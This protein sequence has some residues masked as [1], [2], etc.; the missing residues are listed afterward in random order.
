[1]RPTAAPTASVNAA[2]T[3]ATFAPG[4]HALWVRGRDAAG[5]WGQAARLPVVV[6]GPQPLAVGDSPLDFALKANA[7][8]PVSTTTTIAYGLPL[9]GNVDLAIYDVTG[10][11]IRTLVQGD[12]P[13]GL[14]QVEWDR[15]TGDGRLVQPGV[16]YY[17]LAVAGHRF[18]RR[19]VTLN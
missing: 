8:N 16:Y 7:P 10:R 1:M 18:E 5:N 9:R 13:A 3:T 4:T 11:R 6:N 2:L 15:S 12:V 14:H 17:R 19:M